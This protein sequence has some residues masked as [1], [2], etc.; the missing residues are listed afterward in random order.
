MAVSKLFFVERASP[1]SV[2]VLWLYLYDFIEQFNLYKE[3]RLL[4]TWGRE[5]CI[6]IAKRDQKISDEEMFYILKEEGV[7]WL[8]VKSHQIV[9]HTFVVTVY[10]L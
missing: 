5:Y 8:L 7:K 3:M 1:K 9:L 4:F 10:N 2:H 6:L